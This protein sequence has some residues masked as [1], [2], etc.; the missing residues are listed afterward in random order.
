MDVVNNLELIIPK[1]REQLYLKKI[2][3]LDLL[4]QAIE[5][6]GKYLKLK[7]LDQFLAK[8]GIFLKSQ[9]ITGLLNNC[10]HS[11][12]EIDLIRMI[13]LFRTEIPK[14]IINILNLIFEKISEGQ[15]SMDVEEALL[16]LNIS[17]HPQLEMFQENLEKAKESVL[18][19]LKLIIGDKKTGKT[20][21]CL[22]TIVNQKDKN[23]LCI[24]VAI[25]KTK[26]EVKD[27]YYKTTK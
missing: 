7:E 2:Y 8:F 12:H 21:I 13:Y 26:K 24:Y 10:R 16:H 27:I 1:M 4:Y 14:E 15:P 6:K 18:K 22:D 3:S 23:V 11:E 5:G 17:H 19:G 25:G 20:Q 9:E